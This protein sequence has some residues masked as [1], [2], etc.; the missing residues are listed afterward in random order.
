VFED[1]IIQYWYGNSFAVS[2][3]KNE[4]AIDNFNFS[5]AAQD[6]IAVNN[7]YVFISVNDFKH[8]VTRNVLIGCELQLGVVIILGRFNFGE[9]P[10]VLLEQKAGEQE[11]FDLRYLFFLSRI[12]LSQK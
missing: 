9:K 4:F 1:L 2:I 7:N 11:A 12:N 8:I 3:I 10:S 5:V 6:G